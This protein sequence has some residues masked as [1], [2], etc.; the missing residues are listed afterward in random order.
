MESVFMLHLGLDFNPYPAVHGVCTYYYGT[1]DL[2]GTI[3]E[4]K[5]GI[6]HRGKAGYVVHVPSLHSPEMAHSSILSSAGSERTG[7]T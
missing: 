6:Y 5:D 4:I 7:L 3:D 2:D 1:Y